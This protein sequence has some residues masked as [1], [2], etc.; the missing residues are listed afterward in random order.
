VEDAVRRLKQSFSPR[1]CEVDFIFYQGASLDPSRQQ[2]KGF[3][4][5]FENI[6]EDNRV[7]WEKLKGLYPCTLTYVWHDRFMLD[8]PDLRGLY[9]NHRRAVIQDMR[10]DWPFY[11]VHRWPEG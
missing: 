5:G 11:D 8:E 7:D 10:A 1:G 3:F 2:F 9:G 4:D 6:R